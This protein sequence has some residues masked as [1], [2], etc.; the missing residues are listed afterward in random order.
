MAN[1]FIR[2]KS[3]LPVKSHIKQAK[4]VRNHHRY[5]SEQS[6]LTTKNFELSQRINTAF[7]SSQTKISKRRQENTLIINEP[8]VKYQKFKLH[9]LIK[10]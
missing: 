8:A 3:L 9:S 7:M 10:E 5:H 4:H 1:Q 6:I 2:E